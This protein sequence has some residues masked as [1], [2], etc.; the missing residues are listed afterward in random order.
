MVLGYTL[1]LKIKSLVVLC[2][3]SSFSTPTLPSTTDIRAKILPKYCKMQ[4]FVCEGL[5]MLLKGIWY[6]YYMTLRCKI[7]HTEKYRK[8]IT[9]AI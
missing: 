1:F 8:L 9:P 5:R 2:Y 3:F 6:E 7:T 4:G